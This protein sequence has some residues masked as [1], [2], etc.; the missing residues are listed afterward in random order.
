MAIL[1]KRE[2]YELID[3]KSEAELGSASVT[4][5]SKPRGI[6]FEVDE[7]DGVSILYH[8]DKIYDDDPISRAVVDA[9][10]KGRIIVSVGDMA[11]SQTPRWLTY[12]I[13]HHNDLH[14][15]QQRN[16]L[17]RLTIYTFGQITGPCPIEVRTLNPM[18]LY[19]GQVLSTNSSRSISDD[20]D[21]LCVE[22]E[23]NFYHI[24]P[25][26]TIE[27]E[28]RS[29]N[30]NGLIVVVDLPFGK[31]PIRTKWWG[32]EPPTIDLIGSKVKVRYTERLNGKCVNNLMSATVM[33]DDST[34]GALC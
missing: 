26:R 30:G 9:G 31:R 11:N 29:L 16:W 23:D 10:Y 19:M 24:L 2:W 20:Y 1:H 21:G 4:A 13:L 3:A 25:S 33:G 14:P 27:G 5:Y 6:F 18:M 17:Q 7:V 28:V 34:G 8:N 32:S 12:N 15:N 22:H